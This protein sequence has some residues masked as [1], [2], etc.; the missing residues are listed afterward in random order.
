VCAAQ[1]EPSK[2]YAVSTPG[3]R[4]RTQFAFSARIR[5]VHSSSPLSARRAIRGAA[6]GVFAALIPLRTASALDKQGS[7]HGGGVEGATSGFGVSGSFAA[8]VA[9]YNPTYAARPN[10]TGLTLL[11]AAGHLDIDLIGRR[12]SIPLDVNTWTDRTAR[13]GAR[14]LV[15]SEIDVIGG[16]TSTWRLG[17]GA[18][19]GGARVEHDRGLDGGGYTHDSTSANAQTYADV[20]LRYLMSL[21]AVAPDAAAS[22]ADG[23]VS[24]WLTLGWFAVNRAYFARPDNTG[25]ALFR[26]AAHAEM[27]IWKKRVA[28]ALDGTMFTDRNESAFRPSE[29]DATVDLIMKPFGFELHVAYERDMPVDRGGLVQQLVYVLGVVPFEIVSNAFEAHH[30]P[31]K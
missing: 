7:A 4:A 16:V 15:P 24:G 27:A 11:R 20:R 6:L 2:E 25:L 23:D 9:L 1:H 26:Y 8:G 10:N 12:L 19:E 18:I 28:L 29:L 21:A 31:A 22:L 3:A 13:P 17:P 5:P 14:W 30:E